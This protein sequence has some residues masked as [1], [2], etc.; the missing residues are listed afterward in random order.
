VPS[1]PDFQLIIEEERNN[2]KKNSKK[3]TSHEMCSPIRRNET[4][5]KR[6]DRP[7]SHFHD[8][9]IRKRQKKQEKQFLE[10]FKAKS[11]IRNNTIQCFEQ[12][13][14][15]TRDRESNVTTR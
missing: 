10:P 2:H 11:L 12:Q 1:L 5:T 15:Y 6:T 3:E 14:L 7:L 4:T 8:E 9:I 13:D